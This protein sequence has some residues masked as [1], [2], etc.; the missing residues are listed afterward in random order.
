MRELKTKINWI[1]LKT[2]FRQQYPIYN[3]ELNESIKTFDATGGALLLDVNNGDIIS[4]VSLPTLTSI[5][6]QP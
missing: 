2:Y 1:T 6:E 5:K 4:L 3:K